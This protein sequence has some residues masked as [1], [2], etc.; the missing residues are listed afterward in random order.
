MAI[1]SEHRD[2]FKKAYQEGLIDDNGNF[3]FQK[4][5]DTFHVVDHNGIIHLFNNDIDDCDNL[6]IVINGNFCKN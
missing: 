5:T 3:K 1:P 2:L 6:T 4:S